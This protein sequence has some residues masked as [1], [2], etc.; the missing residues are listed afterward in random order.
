[1]RPYLVYIICFLG[2]QA[3]LSQGLRL[4]AVKSLDTLVTKPPQH[5]IFNKLPSLI[6]N[7]TVYPSA[8]KSPY[9]YCDQ[10]GFFCRW[11]LN[12]DKQFSHPVRF[13]LGS[14]DYVNRLEGK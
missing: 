11:E 14:V 13:R 9:Q 6:V 1:M 3:G 7:K 4:S 12:L 5:L 2:I 8:F 10:I